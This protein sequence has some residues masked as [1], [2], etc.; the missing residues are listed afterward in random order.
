MEASDLNKVA[1]AMGKVLKLISE[2]DPIIYNGDDVYDHKD[3][4]CVIAYIC[5]IG[6]LDRIENNH[7]M[8]NP[9]L[10]IRIPTGIL[11]NRKETMASALNI[12]VN[13]LKEIVSA[14]V[15][16]ENYVEEILNKGRAFYAYDRILPDKFKKSI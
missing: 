9:M 3:D 16:T 4:F 15:V 14:D 10:Q 12:T 6:V 8:L 11:S 7:Y 1:I 5:R 2:L 13:K